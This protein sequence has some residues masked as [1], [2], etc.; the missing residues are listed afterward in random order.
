[1]SVEIK[2]SN[3]VRIIDFQPDLQAGVE[4]LVL[5]IQR[6]EFGLD[7][8]R[9]NQLDL[10]DIP[11]VFQRGK[12]KFWVA[13]DQ[14]AVVGT[15][16]IVDIGNGQAALKKMFVHKNYRGKE[17]G[18]AKALMDEAKSHCSRNAITSIYLGTVGSF[19]AA[20]RF[21]EKNDFVEIPK[22]TLPKAFEVVSV[23]TK[24]YRCSL[25]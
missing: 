12:G 24:F 4:E 5:N 1:M 15:V 11:G 22:D 2:K 16:G 9:E 23:D 21:Y 7:V 18:V 13:I 17:K 10:M 3:L 14:D 8:P 6:N 20:H 19:H 25:K